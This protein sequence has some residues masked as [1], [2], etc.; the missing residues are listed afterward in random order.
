LHV[1]FID[2][3][4]IPATLIVTPSGR[5]ILIDVG[6]SER[7]LSASVGGALPF[8]DTHIDLVVLPELTQPR[9]IAWQ[10]FANRYQI[11]TVLV[12]NTSSDDILAEDFQALLTEHHI[13]SNTVQSGTRVF[14]GDG[15]ALE[16]LCIPSADNR[17]NVSVLLTYGDARILLPGNLTEEDAVTILNQYP[18]PEVTILFLS[19]GSTGLLGDPSFLSLSSPQVLVL[20]IKD[21]SRYAEVLSSL[22]MTGVMQY[23]LGETGSLTLETDGHRM[24]IK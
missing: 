2:A 15:V 24:R 12:G 11:D 19:Q 17:C 7:R 6:D 5:H 23:D 16:M 14:V 21:S 22:E 20:D 13:R 18:S 10:V 9:M 8:W 1:T 4:N 3:G